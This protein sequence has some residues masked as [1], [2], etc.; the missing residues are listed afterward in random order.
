MPKS[1]KALWGFLG[2]TEYYGKFVQSYG[3][4]LAALTQLLKKDGFRR[5]PE[6]HAAFDQRKAAMVTPPVLALPEF[7]K[8]FIVECDASG[9]GM[10]AVLIQGLN[11][12]G[13]QYH[14][15]G[16]VHLRK[17]N[18]RLTCWEEGLSFEPTRRA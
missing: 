7:N 2:L 14:P 9:V 3:S 10:G 12:S 13:I 4:I 15:E 1:I 8:D 11:K 5:T 18:G 16:T 17:G 6:A